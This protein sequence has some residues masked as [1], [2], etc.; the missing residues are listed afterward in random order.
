MSPLSHTVPIPIPGP[1]REAGYQKT[2][3]FKLIGFVSDMVHNRLAREVEAEEIVEAIRP[4]YERGARAMA[5]HVR[6]YI[7]AA[8]S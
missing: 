1:F 4:I 7:H 6:C 5:D 3:S 8:Y 2:I